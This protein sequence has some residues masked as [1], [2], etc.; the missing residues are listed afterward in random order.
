MADLL[1]NLGLQKSVSTFFFSIFIAAKFTY[2]YFL[3]KWAWLAGYLAEF[4]SVSCCKYFSYGPISER[5][6]K[7]LSSVIPHGSSYFLLSSNPHLL[8]SHLLILVSHIPYKKL[9]FYLAG[10]IILHLFERV[11]NG[12]NIP[13]LSVLMFYSFFIV[14]YLINSCTG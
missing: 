7:K 2:I 12:C 8:P 6:T 1:V 14:H 13:L 10:P 3:Y 9:S 4:F 11:T 5:E